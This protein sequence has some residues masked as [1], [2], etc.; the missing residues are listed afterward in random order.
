MKK[1]FF[2]AFLC[3]LKFNHAF[4]LE[5]IK[6]VASLYE[7]FV[8]Y[9][10]GKIVGFDIDLLNKICEENDYRYSLEIVPFAQVL[11]KVGSGEADVGIGAIYVTDERKKIVD[12]TEP[13]LKTG[14]VFVSTLDFKGDINE[15]SNRKIGVKK[16]ATG[17][18]LAFKLCEKF[19]NCQVISFDSTEESV[20]ALVNKKVDL[21]LNDYINTHFLMVKSYRGKIFFVKGLFDNP[22]LITKDYIAFIINKRRPDI[23]SK[24]NKTVKKLKRE[25]YIENLLKFWP[26]IRTYP[27]IEKVIIVNLSF[28]GLIFIIALLGLKHYKDKEI[29]K[30]AHENEQLFNSILNNSPNAVIIH[31]DNGDITFINKRFLN[32]FGEKFKDVNNIF[33]LYSFI[34]INF[35]DFIKVRNFYNELFNNKKSFDIV[36][37]HFVNEGNKKICDIQGAYIGNFRNDELY[38][39]IIRD[40]TYVKELE[41]KFYQSQKLE[42]IGRLAGGIA[43][44]FNNFLTAINGYAYLSLI[45]LNDKEEVRKNLEKIINSSERAGNVTKQLLAFSR[46]QIAKPVVC[47]INHNIKDLEKVLH[48]TVG[49]DIEVVIDLEENLWNVKIDPSQI[50][51]ILMNLVVNARD[52]MPKGGKLIIRTRNKILDEG[53]I[54]GHPNVLAGEYVMIEVEDTGIGMNDEV[55]SHLF[56]PFFTTKERGK[57]TGLGLATVYGI[58]KQNGGYIWVYSELGIGTTF[59]IYLPRCLETKDSCAEEKELKILEGDKSCK[60][61]VVEDDDMIREFIF[62]TLKQSGYEVLVAEN[63]LKA[64]EL[65]EKNIDISL[66]IS[67]IIMPKMSGIELIEKIKLTRPGIKVLMMTGYS[68]EILED[69]KEFIEDYP[70]LEKPFTAL[71]LIETIKKLV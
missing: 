9:K 60:I 61:M 3:L 17:E 56:E 42:S 24:F 39:T 23:F 13:Y 29:L 8:Y 40:E 37:I 27:D 21:V 48:N 33:D 20:E 71:K 67:D 45:N 15:L 51:Q 12:F 10:D 70:L 34:G 62:N 49:E 2:I 25:K 46:K 47:N 30:L 41:E 69:K 63:G 43:H 66:V 1:F 68:E 32:V 52:A 26:E 6:V 18:K 14:L 54:K 64:L 57:G 44:D 35:D 22:K 65:F 36:N 7:P 55:K 38:L 11:E 58:V 31:K 50:D 19:E 16:N 4:A 28:L 59:K 53:Y 5:N